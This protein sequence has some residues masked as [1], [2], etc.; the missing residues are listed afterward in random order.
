MV[1]FVHKY[2]DRNNPSVYTDKITDNITM[3]FKKDKS[4]GD[5]TLFTDRMTEGMSDWMIVLVNPS[6]YTKG[7][8]VEKKGLKKST[9]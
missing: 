3:E 4:Y 8:I 1:K 5:V 7:I 6:I 9:K 2:T